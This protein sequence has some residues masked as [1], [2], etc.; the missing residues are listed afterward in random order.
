MRIEQQLDDVWELEGAAGGMTRAVACDDPC[1][2]VT[3]SAKNRLCLQPVMM[4][5]MSCVCSALGGSG[6]LAGDHGGN[7]EPRV[8][9]AWM[10]GRSTLQ[11]TDVQTRC[12]LRSVHKVQ[13][14]I[15]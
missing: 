15:Y 13:E 6:K 12:R 11:A 9:A 1:D 5:G 10:Q 14:D 3:I 8:A 4:S 2:P 7:V